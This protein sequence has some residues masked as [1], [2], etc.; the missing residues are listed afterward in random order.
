M[1]TGHGPVIDLGTPNDGRRRSKFTRDAG[2]A[3]RDVERPE[4]E[5]VAGDE[6]HVAA[7]AAVAVRAKEPPHARDKDDETSTQAE[8]REHCSR[9]SPK[10]QSGGRRRRQERRQGVD[11][12]DDEDTCPYAYDARRDAARGCVDCKLEQ[13]QQRSRGSRCL[14]DGQR[15]SWRTHMWTPPTAP[16]ANAGE[17]VSL[18]ATYR[19]YAVAPD[20]ADSRIK[21][22]HR[23]PKKRRR[24]GHEGVADDDDADELVD[25]WTV[26][27]GTPH[28]LRSLRRAAD[29]VRYDPIVLAYRALL[30]RLTCAPAPDVDD[31]AWL[32]NGDTE[33]CTVER[34]SDHRRDWR[35]WTFRLRF[36]SPDT[37][38]SGD[39]HQFPT[40]RMIR[41]GSFELADVRTMLTSGAASSDAT[42]STPLTSLESIF[43][44]AQSPLFDEPW[45]MLA[46]SV[47]RAQAVRTGDL[48]A[49]RGDFE[50]ILSV[51]SDADASLTISLQSSSLE[52][53][54]PPTF[55]MPGV[56]VRLWPLNLPATVVQALVPDAVELLF[57][58]ATEL[59]LD[60]MPVDLPESTRWA[61]CWVS[62]TRRDRSRGNLV[63]WPQHLLSRDAHR[64][65]S[66]QA[67]T[68]LSVDAPDA[69]PSLA[70]PPT[71][72]LTPLPDSPIVSSQAAT[73]DDVDLGPLLGASP[74]TVGPVAHDSVDAVSS[75]LTSPHPLGGGE[76]ADSAIGADD[77]ESLT[78]ER[79]VQHAQGLGVTDD[80]FDFFDAPHG[81]GSSRLET[82][83][84]REE[85]AALCG[86]PEM[87]AETPVPSEVADFKQEKLHASVE[88]EEPLPV[89]EERASITSAMV[90]TQVDA[91]REA[92]SEP[93]VLET[94]PD[95]ELLP[96]TDS[97]ALV[98]RRRMH[99]AL[100]CIQRDVTFVRK[101]G[102]GRVKDRKLQRQ[103]LRRLARFLAIQAEILEEDGD[104]GVEIE[105]C[106]DVH[107]PQMRIRSDLTS[108]ASLA[109]ATVLLVRQRWRG[110]VQF[111][112]VR[113][114]YNILPAKR[115]STSAP[116]E[117]PPAITPDEAFQILSRPCKRHSSAP[118]TATAMIRAG[119]SGLVMELS[120]AAIA[121]WQT[122]GLQPLSGRKIVTTGLLY[123]ALA[124]DSSLANDWHDD[125]ARTWMSSGF[126]ELRKQDDPAKAALL[127][128][129]GN[130]N[131]E[132]ANALHAIRQHSERS[133]V[134]IERIPLSSLR[135][136]RDLSSLTLRL[137]DR[138]PLEVKAPRS[139]FL[140]DQPTRPKRYLPAPAFVLAVPPPVPT[141]SWTLSDRFIT[142]DEI[143][144]CHVAYSL[145]DQEDSSGQLCA[146]VVDATGEAWVADRWS[147]DPSSP[148]S[149]KDALGKLFWLMVAFCRAAQL[150]WRVFIARYGLPSSGEI[151]GESQRASKLSCT[152]G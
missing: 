22:Q 136:R 48:G 71:P 110:R 56:P 51:T 148:A 37:A 65:T 55:I 133:L 130:P 72:P 97:L 103:S 86:S 81:P 117:E 14:C 66:Q 121:H 147:C 96:P 40:L 15:S 146:F 8:G 122:L 30:R 16:A 74:S 36:H 18:W 125:L 35:L 33:L 150:D 80:D 105:T 25:S 98:R 6:A 58:E 41:S 5:A 115:K 108:S 118:L 17:V 113:S 139:R 32:V 93:E 29:R 152:K 44:S 89:Y 23:R 126:G 34:P 19:V 69:T 124:V 82:I 104:Q 107:L 143:R 123:D 49:G 62:E 144:T 145:S 102:D 92:A 84:E 42:P 83:E 46:R 61:I 116:D 31:G 141:R 78:G 79:G 63:V 87:T 11:A 101:L 54:S 60:A 120:S 28:A 151:E 73:D 88:E 43:L 24:R 68:A 57:R 128:V 132:S 26:P 111:A 53:P 135:D 20:E 67:S 12:D 95:I 142:R 119:H 27:L 7:V 129:I 112:D 127:F 3:E 94:A 38:S 140:A 21:D 91:T 114:R 100:A 109:D 99:A 106:S 64:T 76:R 2:A 39:D 52:S 75:K 137:Y 70:L 13:R 138:I 131:D 47:D 9:S 50:P 77:W 134:V 59:A 85:Y 90:P 10:A 45:R 4:D 149:L 1:A